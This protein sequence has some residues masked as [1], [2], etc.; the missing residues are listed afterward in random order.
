MVIAIN[1]S[2]VS[3]TYPSDT[4]GS[5]GSLHVLSS[6][7]FKL[8]KGEILFIRGESGGGKSTILRLLNRLIEPGSGSLELYGVDYQSI[9]VLEL[10]R[11]IQLIP[12]TPSLL[13]GIT[14]RENLLLPTPEAPEKSILK[15]TESFNMPADI[16]EKRGGEVS[17]GQAQRLCVIRALLLKPDIILLDEPTAS[18]DPANRENFLKTFLK[19]QGEAGF[20]TVWV[21]HDELHIS[22]GNN[23]ILHLNKGVFDE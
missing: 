4:P 10:R 3:Y 6:I 7:N 21:T 17:V 12:Q 5:P 22:N 8:N 14:V 15:L 1:V 16:L 20:S 13:H 9:D 19:L 23:R 11:R 18:L 2:S